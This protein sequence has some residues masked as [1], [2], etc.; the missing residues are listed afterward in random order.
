[1]NE[2]HM[3][4]ENSG[5]CFEEFLE[6]DTSERKDIVKTVK[7]MLVCFM[8]LNHASNSTKPSKRVSKF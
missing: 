3:A 4:V 6:T 8:Q 5:F 1:M 7:T 2:V